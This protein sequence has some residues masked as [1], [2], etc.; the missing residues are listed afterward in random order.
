M[1]E[2]KMY[3]RMD[4]DDEMARQMRKDIRDPRDLLLRLQACKYRSLGRSV[5]EGVAVEGFQTADPNYLREESGPVDVKIWVALA[6]SLPVRT[7][8]DIQIED[9]THLHTVSTQFQ[10]NVPVDPAQ[11][12]PVIPDG[13][14]TPVNGPVAIPPINEETAVAALGMYR[15]LAGQYPASLDYSV[16]QI[17]EKMPEL[18]G[19]TKEQLRNDKVKITAYVGH[20]MQLNML[21]A[22]PAMLAEEKKDPAYHGDRVT[23]EFPHGVLMRWKVDDGHYRVVFGDLSRRDV[24]VEELARLEAAPLNLKPLAV[25][26][27]PADGAQGYSLTGLQ[28]EW[29]SGLGAVEHRVY[30]GDSPDSLAIAAVVKDPNCPGLPALQQDTQYYWRVDEVQADGSVSQGDIWS[31]KTGTLVGWWRFDESAGTIAPDEIGKNDG[32]LNHMDDSSWVGGVRGNALRFDGVDDYVEI[33]RLIRNDWTIS[34]W[35]NTTQTGS[36]GGQWWQGDGLVDGR[37]GAPAN[38]FGTSLLKD[39][40]AFGVGSPAVFKAGTTILSTTAASDG[41]WHHVVATRRT[42]S[43]QM[44]LYIDGRQEAAATG[45]KGT[46]EAPS[47]L[48]IGV[49]RTDR[50][51]FEGD[52]DEVRLYTYALSD[53]EVTAL[54]QEQAP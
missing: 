4:F 44:R 21:M 11:F 23:P 52:I 34:L 48:R 16:M 15:D 30:L 49:I 26:P 8:E 47:T 24:T 31:F 10:W 6:T 3:V 37:V 53:A 1:H 13:Y 12:E 51:Y 29:M 9:G 42:Q 18:Q 46:K 41:Q 39:K 27:E 17:M 36:A 22:F 43:G 38:D 40:V 20:T 33:P 19:V 50:G 7:E 54:Y 45:P 28:L 25:R 14:T 2:Q 35:I 5:V 32:K